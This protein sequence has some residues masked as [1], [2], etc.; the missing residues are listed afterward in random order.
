MST[1]SYPSHKAFTLVELLVVIGLIAL[2]VAIALPVMAQVRKAAQERAAES[3]LQA[4]GAACESYA[5]TYGGQYPGYFANAE[6][7][8]SS[9]RNNFSETENLVLSLMGQV[10]DESG[11]KINLTGFPPFPTG[12]GVNPDYVGSGPLGPTGRVI[13]PFY[14][15]KANELVAVSGAKNDNNMPEFVDPASGM[16]LL[17]YR[18]VNNAQPVDDF[19]VP[20]TIAAPRSG[21]IGRLNNEMYLDTTGLVSAKNKVVDQKNS[22]LLAESGSTAN[23][24][25]AWLL[26]DPARSEVANG[27]NNDAKDVI[28]GGFALLSA[29][30][31]G[32]YFDKANGDITDSADIDELRSANDDQL[33]V[34]GNQ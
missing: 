1:R 19:S 2:L 3:Q 12:Y 17:Y 22:S 31:D 9:N 15:P 23:D 24:Q 16:P 26:I 5:G 14:I 11:V 4:I 30:A 25:L 34:G 29:G 27:P 28:P 18:M 8:K 21:R 6:F 10:N 33:F 20:S 32:V 7:A 13:D